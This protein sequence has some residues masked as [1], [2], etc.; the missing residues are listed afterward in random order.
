MRSGSELYNSQ[1]NDRQENSGEAENDDSE[2][3]VSL[4]RPRDERPIVASGEQEVSANPSY[5]VT[6]Q[7]HRERAGPKDPI[8]WTDKFSLL[9]SFILMVSTVFLWRNAGRQSK[10]MQDTLDHMKVSAHNRK[11]EFQRQ[12]NNTIS[13]T[14][15]TKSAA[16][17]AR[18]TARESRKANDL[19]RRAISVSEGL[20]MA[21]ASAY[22]IV[23][24]LEIWQPK[25]G[26][27][28]LRLWFV[29]HGATPAQQVQV[30]TQHAVGH[31]TDFFA[32]GKEEDAPQKGGFLTG[33]LAPG[34]RD[35]IE[36]EFHAKK[37][38]GLYQASG[39]T[40]RISGA[41]LWLDVFHNRHGYR[42]AFSFNTPL[43]RTPEEMGIDSF[44]KN[45]F[46]PANQI[47]QYFY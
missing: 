34:K 20:G 11:M 14:N 46:I 5:S 31:F 17:A 8:D 13:A 6:S 40:L 16:T 33:P 2:P 26:D 41:L 25:G 37:Y 30:S 28:M 1:I 12:L 44:Q 47:H 4:P 35:K 15:A 24:K 32:F 10:T 23:E 22:L 38:S 3:E 27:P 42:F 43:P 9:F 45:E 29:N 19:T 39:Q 18:E 21:Q 36:I 7:D